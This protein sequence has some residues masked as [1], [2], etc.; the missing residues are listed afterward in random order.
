MKKKIVAAMLSGSLLM[1][2]LTA[3]AQVYTDSATVQAV[4][5]KLNE[6]G[7]DC[8]TPDG[9]AGSKT[10][11][12]IKAYQEA[13]ALE[14]TGE[15]DDDLLA[16]MGLAVDDQD[17]AQEQD[18]DNA[19]EESAATEGAVEDVTIDGTL[20][21]NANG[22]AV[23]AE[24]SEDKKSVVY[25]VQNNADHPILI[26]AEEVVA[27]DVTLKNIISR[28][29]YG[30]TYMLSYAL[31]FVENKEEYETF[32]GCKYVGVGEKIDFTYEVSKQEEIF[33]EETIEQLKTAVGVIGISK[34][35]N[36][37]GNDTLE[38]TDILFSEYG[39]TTEIDIDGSTWDGTWDEPDGDVIYDEGGV[40]IIALGL[41]EVNYGTASFGAILE[42]KSDSTLSLDN[43]YDATSTL[44]GEAVEYVSCYGDALPGTR[45][46]V[47]IHLEGGGEDLTADDVTSA[48]CQ[49]TLTNDQYDELGRVDYAYGEEQDVD[50]LK[51]EAQEAGTA[52]AQA[53][54]EA[55]VARL[56][57]SIEEQ[58]VY[59]GEGVTI[60]ALALGQ[61]E[62][63][64]SPKLYLSIDNTTDHE[65][66]ISVGSVSVNGYD[67][68]GGDVYML[69]AGETKEE[70]LNIFTDQLVKTGI[71]NIGLIG[72]NL[73][74]YD[75]DYNEIFSNYNYEI[76]TTDF[77]QMD[78][79]MDD[80][81]KSIYS[82]N[83][84]E[85]LVKLE[86]QDGQSRRLLVAFK[87]DTE[88]EQTV[89]IENVKIND[90]AIESEWGG[91][92]LYSSVL[93]GKTS[94]SGLYLDQSILDSNGITDIERMSV[95]LSIPQ[96]NAEVDDLEIPLT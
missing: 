66:E 71:D 46:H 47:A 94:I 49:L 56:N 22:V 14:G 26:A 19:A 29:Y 86:E 13:N 55:A 3:Q 70:E 17:Q 65:V 87:N 83:G 31:G 23:S 64:D 12:A 42:N 10:G 58:T 57:Y 44:N 50:A 75:G 28:E 40:R 33:G 41:E 96:L 69:A 25:H 73:S 72:F 60:K 91:C 4:Q 34:E 53:D 51:A 21:Y 88:T 62:Y 43:A 90:I 61:D 45:T 24:V 15:I 38:D 7:Y 76:K 6:A 27:N 82:E 89:S 20:I 80:S 59:E 8:G 92:T 36:F 68:S 63:S 74:M 67:I 39:E 18:A 85:V 95:K 11:E 35:L 9:V 78:T 81:M 1:F 2:G 5:E 77:D 54:K 32:S 93:P 16:K 30:D 48:Y 52:K 37:D 84:V 79:Q